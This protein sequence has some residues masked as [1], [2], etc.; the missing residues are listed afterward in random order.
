MP[1]MNDT[2]KVQKS[3]KGWKL[4]GLSPALAPKGAIFFCT[5]N[6]MASWAAWNAGPAYHS[7]I[8]AINA[9]YEKKA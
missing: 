1:T 7:V 2:I 5:L 6:E 4:L 8:A 9:K 3:R